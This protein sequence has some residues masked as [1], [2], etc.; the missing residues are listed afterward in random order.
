MASTLLD[1]VYLAYQTA[2]PIQIAATVIALITA[3]I[4]HSIIKTR[5][6]H[7]LSQFPG[8]FWASITRWWIV[9]HLLKGDEYSILYELHKK[10]GPVFRVTPTM[11]MCSD[12][13]M[14]PV[15]YHRRADKSNHYGPGGFGKTPGVFNIQSHDDHVVARKLIASPYSMTNLKRTEPLIDGRVVEWISKLDKEFATTGKT[16]EYSS[17]SSYFTYD[18]I[19]ELAFGKPLGFV[20]KGYDIDDLIVSFHKGALS[21]NVMARLH[22]LTNFFKKTGLGAL[23]LPK[24]GDGSGVG[25]VM[26]IRDDLIASRLKELENPLASPRKDM[27]QSFLDARSITHDD[28]SSLDMENLKAEVL[29]VLLGGAD[30]TATAF[31]ALMYYLMTNPGCFKK[32][33]AEIDNAPLSAI[34]QYDE[35]LQHCP[36]YVACV[37]EALRLCPPTPN[38]FPRV[39]PPGGLNL[40]G[41]FAPEGM[42]MSCNAFVTQRNTDMYG[43]DALEYKPERWL[44]TEKAAEFEKFDF[45]FGYGTRKCMGMNISF[46][47]LYKAPLQLFK[48]YAPRLVKKDGKEPRV[49][50]VGGMAR[51]ENLYVAIEKRKL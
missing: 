18:V 48:G 36:Y 12:P 34:P 11:L 30:T 49:I 27:L 2:T 46:M 29:L 20:E 16:M 35:V 42:E 24:P 8:P 22:P 45:T 50:V 15:I 10:Y 9:Y 17:W 14:L 38:M 6:F 32:V 33:L 47:E 13:K 40:Y 25:N 19:S 21:F 51:W 3:S 7:P 41:K 23:L 1:Q 5:Y 44:D 4:L 39:V 28:G 43:E 26:K 37:K 31:E